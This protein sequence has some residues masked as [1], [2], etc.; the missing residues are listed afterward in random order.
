MHFTSEY[1]VEFPRGQC[2]DQFGFLYIVATVTEI[3]QL[4][5]A[6][7]AHFVFICSEDTKKLLR[8]SA[9][10]VGHVLCLDEK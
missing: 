5:S 9:G 2:L 3:Q 6:M 1:I 10:S 7:F 8:V 4:T